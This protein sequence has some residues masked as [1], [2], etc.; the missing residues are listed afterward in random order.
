MI[1]TLHKDNPC[2]YLVPFKPP[3]KDTSE[4]KRGHRAMWKKQE[5]VIH[6]RIVKYITVEPDGTVH[7]LVETDKN[8]SE[9]LHMECKDTGEFLHREHT[10]YE[11]TE[12]FDGEELTKDTIVFVTI[13]SIVC[14]S[15]D[16]SCLY[17]CFT[18]F[19]LHLQVVVTL[20]KI[21]F[22]LGIYMRFFLKYVALNIHTHN[23]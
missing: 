17:I 15:I 4:K 22:F 19:W 2:Q 5:T 9:V 8:Q 23:S 1:Q 14:M 7:E 16:S 10:E 13:Y 6:E 18:F 20:T 3:Q 21:K 11:Q 12:K